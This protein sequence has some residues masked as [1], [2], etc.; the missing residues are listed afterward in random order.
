LHSIRVK[1]V[2]L[3]F[4][5]IGQSPRTDV[6][7]DLPQSLRSLKII[8]AGALDNLTTQ[9]IDSLAPTTNQ[10]VYV[11]RLRN[12]SEVKIAKERL[13][14]LL[15]EQI[16]LLQRT[17]ADTIVLLCS[18]KFQLE[19]RSRLIFPSALLE[20]AVQAVHDKRERLGVLVPEKT[21]VHD[22]EDQWSAVANDVKAIS[23]SPYTGSTELLSAASKALSDRNLIVL[24][25]FGYTDQHRKT[26]R[27]VSG[28][29]AISAKS[30]TFRFLEELFT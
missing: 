26:V 7:S 27:T 24:D 21:Q 30:I 5:T 29:P 28:K 13:I 15:N 2:A 4:L 10:T 17:D 19:Y 9:Q 23:F 18:G 12:G 22:A 16:R 1:D 25:C 14:P 8:E 6:T 11:S 3:G 20:H